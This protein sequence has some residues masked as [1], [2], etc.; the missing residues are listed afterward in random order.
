MTPKTFS[1]A[2]HLGLVRLAGRRRRCTCPGRAG[3]SSSRRRPA[4][5]GCRAGRGRSRSGSRD[6]SS[7]VSSR[8]R[9]RLGRRAGPATN[10]SSAPRVKTTSSAHSTS[11][12][13]SW[14]ATSTCTSA[15]L[16]RLFHVISSSRST[17]TSTL[18]RSQPAPARRRGLGA[19]RVA[20]RRALDDVHA[21]VAGAVRQSAAQRR[22]LH[23]LGRPL[24]VVAR[25]G[26]V[27]RAAAGELRRAGRALTGAA[28][29]LLLV[30][31]PATAADLAAGLGV[32][33]ALA[34]RR[35][36]RDDDLVDQRD[37]GLDVEQLLGQ[38]RCRRLALASST[39]TVRLAMRQAPFAAVLT[40]TTPRWGRARRP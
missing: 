23:L 6:T 32:V 1:T 9:A 2:W 16:R 25:R 36:L 11:Y 26:A 7:L 30:R 4:R 8:S 21:A 29:A 10:A 39:S 13:F 31:L 14:S 38:Q 3:R 37:V 27:D 5:A 34:R 12:V 15:R 20:G 24:G 19:R 28:G 40:R 22:R 35:E 33:R 17:T 18:R